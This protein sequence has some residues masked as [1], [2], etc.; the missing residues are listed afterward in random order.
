MA[1]TYSNIGSLLLR[2]CQAALQISTEREEENLAKAAAIFSRNLFAGKDL[3]K[4][5]AVKGWPKGEF[6]IYP[7]IHFKW[8][9]SSIAKSAFLSL[10]RIHREDVCKIFQCRLYKVYSLQ[11]ISQLTINILPDFSVHLSLSGV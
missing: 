6:P 7:L 11:Q 3:R 1:R 5:K 8:L 10:P 2:L 4:H 9:F